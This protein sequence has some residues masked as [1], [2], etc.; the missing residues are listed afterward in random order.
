MIEQRVQNRSMKGWRGF[1]L[2]LAVAA[3]VV[4]GSVF[5]SFLER[6]IGRASSLLFILFGCVVAWFLLDWYVLD[7]LYTC[8]GG[9]LR[10][11][12]VYGKRERFMLDV[13]L[14]SIQAYGSLEAM[15]RRFPDAKVQR[16]V[17]QECPLAPLAVA[18]TDD[19]RTRI[20]L[21]QP[22]QPLR[23]AIQRTLKK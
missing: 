4:V 9:C 23:E 22:D 10:I 8:A 17:K 12:R 15:K 3:L 18:Y 14:N 2:V 1:A 11:C 7:Y 16:A 6:W 20:L 19:G 5:F 13:W 21:I